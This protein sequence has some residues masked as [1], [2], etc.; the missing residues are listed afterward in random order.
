[1][2]MDPGFSNGCKVACVNATGDLLSVGVVHP[3]FDERRKDAL[4]PQD[5]SWIVKQVKKKL[6]KD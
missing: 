3:V 5:K 2:G 1:M 6:A 4:K